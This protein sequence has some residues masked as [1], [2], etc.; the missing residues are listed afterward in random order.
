MWCLDYLTVV[1]LVCQ[2]DVYAHRLVTTGSGQHPPPYSAW[3]SISVT[4]AAGLVTLHS[5]HVL[6]TVGPVDAHPSCWSSVSPC[7]VPPV[8]HSAVWVTSNCSRALVGV[9]MVSS[10]LTMG[11]SL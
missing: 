3:I 2:R 6:A 7:L 9:N 10:P 8:N 1:K 4:P 5:V 11:I